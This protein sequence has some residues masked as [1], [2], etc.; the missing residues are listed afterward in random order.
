[1][2]L[3][4]PWNGSPSSCCGPGVKPVGKVTVSLSVKTAV[5][6]QRGISPMH[7]VPEYHLFQELLTSLAG[8]VPRLLCSP[9]WAM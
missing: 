4:M 9:Q 5:V 1:M 2:G 8:D 7:A 3:R 6:H